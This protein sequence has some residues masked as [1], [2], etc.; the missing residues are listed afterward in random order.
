MSGSDSSASCLALLGQQDFEG[1]GVLFW[2]DLGD[3]ATA[4]SRFELGKSGCVLRETTKPPRASVMSFGASVGFIS[5]CA[6]QRS[7][8]HKAIPVKFRWLRTWRVRVFDFGCAQSLQSEFGQFLNINQDSWDV[9][10]AQEEFYKAIS[11]VIRIFWFNVLTSVWESHTVRIS[12]S[13][14]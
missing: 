9:N 12:R 4:E 8:V 13:R 5:G 10:C 3:V 6:E 2:S 14:I 11:Y 1:V 7:D